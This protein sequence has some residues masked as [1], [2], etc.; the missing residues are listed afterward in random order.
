MRLHTDHLTGLQ[1]L[2]APGGGITPRLDRDGRHMRAEE[3][4]RPASSPRSSATAPAAGTAR[5]GFLVC[6]AL[7]L[8]RRCSRT[9]AWQAP[10]AWA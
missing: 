6:A 10:A 7:I 3:E 2:S 9:I 5:S 8:K 4:Q 1:Y